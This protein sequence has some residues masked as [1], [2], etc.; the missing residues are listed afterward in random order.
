MKNRELVREK[1]LKN[2]KYPITLQFNTW[3]LY[4]KWDGADKTTSNRLPLKSNSTTVMNLFFY[5]VTR[6]QNLISWVMHLK[7][8]WVWWS[9]CNL[10]VR[11]MKMKINPKMYTYV[12]HVIISTLSG[13]RKSYKFTLGG[14]LAQMSSYH[15]TNQT[16]VLPRIPI[17]AANPNI[18]QLFIQYTQPHRI[19]GIN[20]FILHFHYKKTRK[21][22]Q[23][24]PP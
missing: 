19:F 8:F 20:L 7:A 22:K 16:M 4:G 14:K 18:L 11:V 24:Q 1:I 17:T 13:M 6:L 15:W 12:P 21:N 10:D 23:Q 2:F 5:L 3:F 9:T